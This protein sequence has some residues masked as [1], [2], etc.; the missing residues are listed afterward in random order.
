MDILNANDDTNNME[1]STNNNNNN[2]NVDSSLNDNNDNDDDNNSGDEEGVIDHE[3]LRALSNYADQNQ[4]NPSWY[5]NVGTVTQR[6]PAGWQ[7]YRPLSNLSDVER[8]EIRDGETRMISYKDPELYEGTG[9]SLDWGEY[10]VADDEMDSSDDEQSSLSLH[11]QA[12]E[13][14]NE[15]LDREER[16]ALQSVR[17]DLE[18]KYPTAAV[19]GALNYLDQVKSEFCDRP[20]IYKEFLDI[21]KSFKSKALDTPSVIRRVTS[22][23]NGKTQLILGFKSY[24]PEGYKHMNMNYNQMDSLVDVTASNPTLMGMPDIILEKIL[25]YSTDRSATEQC[26]LELVC[27]RIRRLTTGD[28]FWSRHPFWLYGKPRA[29]YCQHD[30]GAGPR[31]TAFTYKGLRNIRK[32]QKG[33]S[34]AIIDVLGVEID[35]VAGAFRTLSADI[36]SRLNH[37]GPVALFR[38]R[39]D[40]I[41]YICE[42]LQGY[43]I[44]RLGMAMFLAI[45][46][47]GY[48]PYRC[49][50]A[51]GNGTRCTVQTDDIQLAFQKDMF[52]PFFCGLSPQRP[53]RCNV[54]KGNHGQVSALD[55][56][57]S[58]SSSSGMV[59]KWPL[60]NCHDVLPPE[61]GRRII[62]RLAYQAGI[63]KMS[64][65]AFLL[66]EA[67]LLHALG[68]LLVNAYESSVEM[69]KTTKF[70]DE[71]KDLAYDEPTQSIDMFKTPPPPFQNEQL[72]YTI[73]PGQIS[74][75]AE[76]RDITPSNVY[77]DVWV[78]SLGFTKD[79]EEEIERSY[80]YQST[81][82]SCHEVVE[83]SNAKQKEEPANDGNDSD[84]SAWSECSSVEDSELDMDDYER[85]S[86]LVE[87]RFG[88]HDI[89]THYNHFPNP[90]NEDV[91]NGEDDNDE[92]MAVDNDA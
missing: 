75:A 84:T 30:F 44:D 16:Q 42:L 57:C 55:C 45:H 68:V 71:E 74:A 56:S 49:E 12:Q 32:Y 53:R 61:A 27:K 63:M 1:E 72:V 77:G 2:N 79:E 50:A 46:K 54:A 80:Y 18:H 21:M 83:S 29:T 19:E 60:D 73:V 70:L 38:L 88:S 14:D 4:D 76:E 91:D 36:L 86:Y 15:E 34:N 28:G 3:R 59:W 87:Y 11:E 81:E 39:G 22:L 24:L 66:A 13:M 47:L 37:I 9:I 78:A 90:N 43:M 92:D 40:T 89:E 20:D 6:P 51:V 5:W 67:E 65:E 33:S 48:S 25:H 85:D 58:I 69:S 31:E 52:S 82:H 17:N 23:F 64:S 41:G 10:Y 62:R 7:V 26:V 8:K 35:C